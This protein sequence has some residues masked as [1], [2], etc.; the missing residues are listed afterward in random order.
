M[1]DHDRI[2]AERLDQIVHVL[3]QRFAR[4]F[5]IGFLFEGRD[6]VRIERHE[7]ELARVHLGGPGRYGGRPLGAVHKPLRINRG[8]FRRRLAVLRTVLE[9][10]GVP[11]DIVQRWVERE[12]GL[13]SVIT[14][15]TDCVPEVDGT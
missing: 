12:R 2:G 11:A 14:D 3:V 15:G 13:E 10:E 8:H 5:I 9:A 1:T 4:D 6:L 7:L